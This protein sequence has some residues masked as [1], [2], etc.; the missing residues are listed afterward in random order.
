MEYGSTVVDPGSQGGRRNPD[1]ES[2]D[3]GREVGFYHGWTDLVNGRRV[4]EDDRGLVHVERQEV[5][6]CERNVVTL[7]RRHLTNFTTRNLSPTDPPRV[8]TVRDE[9][10]RTHLTRTTESKELTF[11][12]ILS[13][14]VSPITL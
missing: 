10:L 4:G 3:E 14:I 7:H 5:E 1:P 6:T 8:E 13:R 12:P 9:P 2:N 11:T